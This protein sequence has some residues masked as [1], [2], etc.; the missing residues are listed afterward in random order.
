M[1]SGPSAVRPTRRRRIGTSERRLS[2]GVPCVSKRARGEFTLIAGGAASEYGAPGRV[3]TADAGAGVNRTVRRRPLRP[4]WNL[5]RSVR[6]GAS[7]GRPGRPGTAPRAQ[8]A[9]GE[10]GAGRGGGSGSRDGT[11]WWW[12][13]GQAERGPQPAPGMRLGH[14]ARDPARTAGRRSWRRP[15]RR[16]RRRSHRRRAVPPPESTS[17]GR[18]IHASSVTTPAS[19]S[20]VSR[21]T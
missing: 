19:S 9:D 11:S 18:S 4:D 15:S 12:L 20:S 7:G 3:R 5:P 21:W 13:G 2:R 17:S 6:Q 10:R 1:R 14:R 16:G 8:P